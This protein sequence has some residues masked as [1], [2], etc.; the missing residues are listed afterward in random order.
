LRHDLVIE[1]AAFRLR[2]ALVSDSAFILGLRKDPELARFLHPV[3]GQLEDQIAWMSAYEKR[4]GDWYW[5]IETLASG[6]PEGAVGLYNAQAGQAEWG[7]WILRRGSLAAMECAWLLYRAAFENLQLERVY[8]RTLI[9]NK[10]VVSFHDSCGLRR[11][12]VVPQCF[13]IGDD[14]QDAVEHEMLRDE[15][16]RLARILEPKVLR[17]AEML[18]RSDV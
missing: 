5:I 6:S 14:S 13:A 7:R 18:E 8:C 12:G 16:P 17:L 9:E 2:P 10:S 11:S 15:W 4:G 3:T 1:G